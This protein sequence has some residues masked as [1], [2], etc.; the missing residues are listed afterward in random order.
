M[1]KTLKQATDERMAVIRKETEARYRKAAAQTDN[2]AEIERLVKQIE[3]E[4]SDNR[5]DQLEKTLVL[6]NSEMSELAGLAVKKIQR[7]VAQGD[8]RVYRALITFVNIVQAYQGG[9]GKAEGWLAGE[10]HEAQK[11]HLR[12]AEDLLGPQFV[13]IARNLGKSASANIAIVAKILEGIENEN[14]S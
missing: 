10:F 1:A 4:E 7:L 11:A 6:L 12:E 9:L 2:L 13:E 14:I 5:L 3:I 8:E